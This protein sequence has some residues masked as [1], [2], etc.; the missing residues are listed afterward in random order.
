MLVYDST[1]KA[2]AFLLRVRL[3]SLVFVHHVPA[4]VGVSGIN[5]GFY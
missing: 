4:D 5:I 3:I 1:V 2:S